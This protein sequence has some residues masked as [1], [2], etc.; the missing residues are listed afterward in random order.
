M[1]RILTWYDKHGD[2]H[3]EATT[4]EQLDEAAEYAVI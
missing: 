2:W 1:G 4:D 3:Y